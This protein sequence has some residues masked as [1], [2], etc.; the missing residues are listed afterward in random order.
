[1]THSTVFLKLVETKTDRPYK[2]SFVLSIGII[3]FT[4]VLGGIMDPAAVSNNLSMMLYVA[5]GIII[6]VS[7]SLGVMDLFNERFFNR[8]QERATHRVIKPVFFHF[9]SIYRFV[10]VR[11][12]SQRFNSSSHY[13]LFNCGDVDF[14]DFR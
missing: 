3:I 14:G 4:I 10:A 6:V 7:V 13:L 11:V 1:M 2:F 9:S 12:Q 5:I 8:Q